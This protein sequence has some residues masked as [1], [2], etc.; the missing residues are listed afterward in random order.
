MDQL[1]KSECSR[2]D[3]HI[4]TCVNR[5]LYISLFFELQGTKMSMVSKP[6]CLAL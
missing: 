5:L 1:K 4:P 6:A 2:F 3:N